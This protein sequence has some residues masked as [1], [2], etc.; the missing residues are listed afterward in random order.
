[1]KRVLKVL[2][3]TV[4]MTGSLVV[5]AASAADASTHGPAAKPLTLW[6]C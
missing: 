4:A 6:C 5:G 3:V 2:T 1:M